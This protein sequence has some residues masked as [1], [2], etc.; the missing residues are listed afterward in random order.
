MLDPRWHG[1]DYEDGGGPAEGLAIARMLGMITYQSDA[2]MTQRFDR[3]PAT[4]PSGWPV[5]GEPFDVEGYLHYQGDALVRR[6][7]ANTYLYLSRAMDLHDVGRGHASYEAALARIQSRV[8][9]VGVTTDILFP[10]S[11]VRALAGDLTR[12]GKAVEY[13]QLD[14]PH[15]HDAFLVEFERMAPMLRRCAE[16]GTWQAAHPSPPA[17]PSD[18]QVSAGVDVGHYF[19]NLDGDYD[20]PSRSEAPA[21]AGS[22][23]PS[24]IAAYASGFEASGPAGRPDGYDLDSSDGRVNARGAR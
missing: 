8:F 10:D 22:A 16:E 15:G 19:R 24:A 11:H 21:V 18:E 17:A 6:F 20:E 14:S 23:A 2:L 12:L 7:D 1:G 9:L 5:F 3:R 4:R 13:W